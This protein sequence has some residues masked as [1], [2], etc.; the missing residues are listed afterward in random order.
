MGLASLT[1]LDTP[2]AGALE[3][4]IFWV[5]QV[6][7]FGKL[8]AVLQQHPTEREAAIGAARHVRA[9]HPERVVLLERDGRLLARIDAQPVGVG[10]HLNRVADLPFVAR[11]ELMLRVAAPAPERAVEADAAGVPVARVD[12]APVRARHLNGLERVAR[13]IVVGRRHAV[14]LAELALL[15][16]SPAIERRVGEQR[17]HVLE[18]VRDAARCDRQRHAHRC[19]PL[20][21]IALAELSSRVRSPAVGGADLVERAREAVLLSVASARCTLPACV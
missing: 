14:V 17:A 10:P 16:A 9:P 2:P 7:Q 11:A 19:V 4:N 12:E 1:G 18:V 8:L 6:I 20:R 3:Q 13:R 15:I 5:N 21:T